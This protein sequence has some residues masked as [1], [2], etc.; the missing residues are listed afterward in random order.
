MKNRQ[1][2]RGI[3][4][5]LIASLP[6]WAKESFVTLDKIKVEDTSIAMSLSGEA[7]YHA[8]KIANPPRVIVEFTNTEHNVNQ[9][10]IEVNGKLIK[11]IRSGQFQNEPVKIARVVIDLV[12]AAEYQL[13]GDKNNVKLILEPA[14]EQQEPAASTS[15]PAVVVAEEAG[16]EAP[17]ESTATIPSNEAATSI[18]TPAAPGIS[19]AAPDKISKKVEPKS[20]SK[21]QVKT[22]PKPDAVTA[23]KEP[24]SSTKVI[25]PK[26]A[27]TLD[28]EEADIRDVLRVL[29]IKSNINIIYGTD[30]SG[31]I[32][33]H[34]DNVP[35][36]KAFET[37]LSVRGLVSQVQGPNILRV[38]TPQKISEER[39]QAV[40]FTKIFPLNYAKA[41]E[42]KSNLDII[43][44]AEG[45]KG[46]ISI[47]ARTNSLVVTDTPE[48]LIS[49][50]QVISE[51]DKKPPQVIIEAK[52]VEV[53]LN[54][55]FDMGIQ[56]Q[57]ASTA[58]NQNNT[59]LDI[60]QTKAGTSDSSLGGN[61]TAGGSVLSVVSPVDGG[62]GIV[63]PASP[64]GG[65]IGAIAFGMMI[66]N[67]RLTGILTALSQKGLSKILSTPR[68]TTI[69]N[70][71]A[72]IL[73]GQRVPFSTTTIG[74]GGVSQSSVQWLE[75]GIKLEV[76]PTINTDQRITLKIKPEVSLVTGVS[77]AGPIVATRQ[78]DTT[79]MVKNAETIVIG[80]LIREE[81]RKLG[82]QVPLLGELPIIGHLFR[83]DLDTKERSELLVF[84]TP[85][86]ID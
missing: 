16:N 77:A 31:T 53:L 34:L 35:F 76:T 48:G 62:T 25:L 18:T 8:F 1:I 12:K 28:F 51:L 45:R 5:L 83:R 69:N 75:V 11:R 74:A 85:Q 9:K 3:I 21:K 41:E 10:E 79:V 65:Q 26:G 4:V 67:N 33:I 49:V 40:T 29:S 55:N 44:S 78:A 27:V 86:I 19:K 61:A 64:V 46:N 15:E 30:V 36:D 47:D 80:G 14:L 63:F 22:A 82:T 20:T 2:T 54:D 70:Q 42:V 7:K 43:R 56:W 39:S 23:K 73:I 38:A 60:G 57:Y 50:E 6:L 52:L 58:Y 59:R 17:V 37:I 32:S 84:I 68:V 13:Q 71:I 66:D 72:R 81:D 24:A